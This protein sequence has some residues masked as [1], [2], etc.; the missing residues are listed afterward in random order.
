MLRKWYIV[1]PVK[2]DG[3]FG[4][5]GYQHAII[6]NEEHFTNAYFDF[7]EI[8]ISRWWRE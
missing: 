5:W 4:G 8:L 2:Y 6:Y 1:L 3:A 7:I